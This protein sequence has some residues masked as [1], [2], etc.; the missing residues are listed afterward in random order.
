[1]KLIVGC[2]G[3]DEENIE[4]KAGLGGPLGTPTLPGEI[5]TEYFLFGDF[6]RVW[7]SNVPI[8]VH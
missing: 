3:F 4:I 6:V 5:L 2:I 8:N 7:G 1:M